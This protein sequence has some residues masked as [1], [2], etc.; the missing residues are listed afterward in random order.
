[1]GKKKRLKISSLKELK[2]DRASKRVISKET[3]RR[4]FK[5]KYEHKNLAKF[6]KTMAAFANRDGGAL[7]FGI[8][9]RP[10]DVVGLSNHEIPDDVTFTNFLKEFFQPE[11]EFDSEILDIVGSK[12]LCLIVRPASRKPVICKK[13]KAIVI[14]Q[15]T[16]NKIILREGA[17][18]YRYFSST[19]EIKYAD[20][21]LMLDQERE[22]FFK[23]MVD[24][25]TLLNT[26]GVN[27]A[28]VVNAHELSGSDQAASVYLTNDTAE[29]L[30]WIDS[31]KFVE[32]EH[33][34]SKA[35][36]VVSQVEIKHGVEVQTATDYA[37][38]HPMTKTALSKAVQISGTGFD[39][40]TWKL[41]IK[42][43]PEYHHSS[44]HGKNNVHK[45]TLNSE[46]K[47][48]AEYPVS[49]DRRQDKIKET[50]EQYDSAL[51]KK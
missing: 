21:I 18:Y 30:N 3:E 40:V 43:N 7:F 46:E 12:V 29:N 39:A 48:L 9:D 11:I 33:D 22:Q 17:I 42:D 15:G 32:D 28:A 2:V 51:R 37:E 35:Y 8:K 1:M 45:F 5:L 41:G 47:I 6:A 19:D 10:R 34:G 50:I 16:S 13:E 4:E 31:G 36:Y 26:V 14:K 49:M 44:K 27:K 20:L 38:T 23:S 24:N 25:I